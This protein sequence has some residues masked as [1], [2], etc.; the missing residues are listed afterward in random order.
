MPL[1]KINELKYYGLIDRKINMKY[2]T[3]YI[4]IEI[5]RLF[6]L[7]CCLQSFCLF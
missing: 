1:T 4:V 3:T 7:M 6:S 5:M 2:L